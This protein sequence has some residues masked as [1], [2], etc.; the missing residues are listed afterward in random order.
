[1]EPE[2][3][4]A[5]SAWMETGMREQSG[6]SLRPGTHEYTLGDN[7]K[8]FRSNL[9][10][11]LC[12]RLILLMTTGRSGI[13]LPGFIGYWHDVWPLLDDEEVVIIMK[14]GAAAYIG[15][16]FDA[17]MSTEAKEN[18]VTEEQVIAL[19]ESSQSLDAWD[20]N[21]DSVKAACNGYPDFWWESI[22]QSGLGDRVSARWGGDTKVHLFSLDTREELNV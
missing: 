8:F 21:A 4:D 7:D 16:S 1:M 22:I 14:A 9:P 12:G 17:C 19:M 20:N 13:A 18:I 5:I 6:H 15:V 11:A 3:Q 2:F 10:P